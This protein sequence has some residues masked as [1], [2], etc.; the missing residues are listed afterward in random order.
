MLPVLQLGP[1]ALPTYPLALILAGWVALSVA[2]RAAKR[3]GVDPDHIYNAGLYGFIAAVVGGRLA[4]VVVYWSAY[5]SQPLE[6]FGFNTTAFL[7]W[8]AILAGLIV[9]GLYVYRRRL[10]LLAMLDAFAPGLLVGLAIAAVGAFL[11]GRNPG[12]ASSLPWA[13]EQWGLRRHPVQ[14]YEAAGLLAVAALTWRLTGHAREGATFLCAL[15][16]WGLVTWF[17]EAFRAPELSQTILGGLRLM[18]VVGLL[19]ALLAL[20]GFRR[21]VSNVE[22]P[23]EPAAPDA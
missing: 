2:G 11:A 5:R 13:V 10:P 18:Q 15:A 9:A 17:V 19:A 4:H 12:A 20:L 1:L 23:Q 14:L 7:L 8:P 3:L 22:A 21:M 6:I 16:G